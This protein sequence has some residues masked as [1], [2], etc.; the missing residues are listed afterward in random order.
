MPAS[1]R[2]IE[3]NIASPRLLAHVLTGKYCKHYLIKTRKAHTDDTPVKVLAPDRQEKHLEQHLCPIRGACR[4]K[5]HDVVQYFPICKL[6][7]NRLMNKLPN[8]L[9]SAASMTI[10][11]RKQHRPTVFVASWPQIHLVLERVLTP[12]L[13]HPAVLALL[14]RYPSTEKLA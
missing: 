11:L 2:P 9:C 4:R 12:R 13:D 6:T 10:L 5:I 14:L 1:S 7:S 8:S 3:H